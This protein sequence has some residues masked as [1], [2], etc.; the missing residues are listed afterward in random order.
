MLKRLVSQT[1]F[2]ISATMFPLAAQAAEDV[3]KSEDECSQEILLSYFPGVFV[4]ET[5]N[6]FN[7]PKDQVDAIKREL[8]A[9]D[10]EI[11]KQVEAK[12]S[13]MSPNPLKDP[14]QR[15]VAVKLFRE[16]LFEN[17]SVVMKAH[18]VKDDKQI[19]AML[20]DIQQQKAKRFARCM[21]MQRNQIQS[22]EGKKPNAALS[23]QKDPTSMISQVKT[24]DRASDEDDIIDDDDDDSDDDQDDDDKK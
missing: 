24:P 22:N 6:R 21:E 19:Q 17:F 9:R 8:L 7:I 15:Q 20:D 14:E 3:T 5:L 11:I 13:K 1:L 10:K 2:G 16:T 18:G 23:S 12:A 4:A